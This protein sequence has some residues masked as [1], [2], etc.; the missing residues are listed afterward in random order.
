MSWRDDSSAR[1]ACR[2]GTVREQV[3]ARESH[4]GGARARRFGGEDISILDGGASGAAQCEH[5]IESTVVGLR[6]EGTTCH[7]TLYRRGALPRAS[8]ED[9]CSQVGARLNTAETYAVESKPDAGQPGP[10]PDA[11]RAAPAR[12]VVYGRRGRSS[13][14]REERLLPRELRGGGFGGRL[15]TP[16][17]PRAPTATSRPRATP[18]SRRTRSSTRCA[19]PRASRRGERVHRRSPEERASSALIA[20]VADRVPPRGV[21]Q[22][23]QGIPHG[24]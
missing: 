9:I 16:K 7:L 11:L 4:D 23:D 6:T 20:G 18:K 5:G 3:R 8:L 1:P 13:G 22:R 12:R 17:R 15:K 14:R 19:G 21:G 2:R 24:G 10:A